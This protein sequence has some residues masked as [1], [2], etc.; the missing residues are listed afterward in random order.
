MEQGFREEVARVLQEGVTPEEVE[1]AKKALLSFRRLNRS[2]DGTL[3]ST[4]AS[5]LFLDRTFEISQKV[6]DA[7]AALTADQVNAALRRHLRPQ[8]FVTGLGGDFKAQP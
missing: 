7:L 4:L 5:N 2:Q 8:A 3:A 1:S 6:D